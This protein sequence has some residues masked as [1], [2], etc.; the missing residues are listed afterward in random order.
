MGTLWQDLRYGVRMLLKNPGFTFVA[1]FALAL[2]IG[3]NTAI[4]SVVNAALLQPL[5]FEHSERL[6]RIWSTNPQKGAMKLSSSFLG[7]QDLQKE[8]HVFD[9]IAAYSSAS[10]TITGGG[11]PE[12]LS[13]VAVAGDLFAVA[14]VRPRLGRAFTPEEIGEGAPVAVINDEV[15][16]RHFNSD[17][18]VTGR[19]VTLDQTSMTIIGV[20]PPKFE[21]PFELTPGFWV[22]L[23]PADELNIDRGTRYL[24]MVAR[25]KP[26][27]SLETARAEMNAIGVRLGAEYPDDH[28]GRGV[29]VMSL[30]ESFVG[31][32]RP[33]LLVLLGAIGFV[34]LIACANVANL[35]LARA[36]TRSRE[37]AVRTVLGASRRR[38]IRQLL[39]ESLLLAVVGGGLGLLLAWWAND[40]LAAAV[41]A[42]VPRFGEIGIDKSVLA[43]ALLVSALTGVLFG[44]APALQAAKTDLN[45][46]LKEGGR[47]ATEGW[48]RNRLRSLLVVSEIALS[49]ML[50]VGA[51]LLVQSFWRLRAVDPGFDPKNVI[52]ATAS[53]SGRYEEEEQQAAFFQATVNR[54]AALPGVE[55]A[56]AIFPLPLNGS[57]LSGDFAMIGQTTATG[58]KPSANFRTVTP[59][60]MRAMGIPLRKGRALTERDDASAPKVLL[61]NETLARRYFANEDPIGRQ[62][63]VA[64]LSSE[65]QTD[66]EIVG[67]VGDVRHRG[68]DAETDAEFYLS[69]LQFPIGEMSLVARTALPNPT[70]IVPALRQ[71]VW[72]VD[73]DQPIY[74]IKTMT[75]WLGESTAERR[76]NMLLLGSFA[77]VALVLAAVGIF[78]VMSYS[79]A[80]RTHEIGIRMA[81]G[82]QGSDVVRLVVGQ[83][84]MLALAGV[85]VGATG[86]LV[87][88]S[89][90][91]SLLYGVSASDPL[92]FVAVGLL[93][94]SVALLACYIPAR[95]ATKVDP[96][97]ALRYE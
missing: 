25:L 69:H 1:V 97:V 53:L 59:D 55:A 57:I 47:A 18:D 87:L 79:V 62:L 75:Q 71:A 41:P 19:Q 4:F 16:R 21:F 17:P 64:T 76:F 5:P 20:M 61:I 60:Y 81:L 52:T 89:V 65:K 49:L 3:A 58:E 54:I 72:A 66:C 56:G 96:M 86:A 80:R 78:G 36:A 34:L 50:L 44:L 35:L 32:V 95:R 67:V 6:V 9:A 46:T 84:M 30:H 10:A 28:A 15:W 7:F 93:L 82:A 12:Q 13:G 39:T 45:E 92:T 43:F 70:N 91:S 68:L 63:R 8:N 51:G 83:G 85:A 26:G 74:E 23:D 29:N 11:E 31:N 94:M 22:L 77:V 88:T 37:I 33:A 73:K 27:V 38:I 14:G 40:L 2:G 42:E 24:S 90:V 48:R